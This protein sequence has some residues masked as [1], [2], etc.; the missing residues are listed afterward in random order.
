MSLYHDDYIESEGWALKQIFD[1]GLYIRAIKVV[2]IPRC[3]TRC[4]ASEVAQGYK[5]V[6]ERSAVVRF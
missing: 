3:G 6:K 1:K 5:T 4:P 2:L